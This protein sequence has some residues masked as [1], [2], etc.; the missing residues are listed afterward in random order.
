MDSAEQVDTALGKALARAYRWQRMLDEGVCG[1]IGELAKRESVN[2]A[3]VSRVLRLTLL[4]PE[5]VEAI[6]DGRQQAEV[7]LDDLLGGVS[8]GVGKITQISSVLR[9]RPR[10]VVRPCCSD[11]QHPISAV[12]MKDVR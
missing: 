6:L 8:V 1:T 3:Y 9:E 10:L 2:R 11:L 7:G 12:R 4:A 5:I